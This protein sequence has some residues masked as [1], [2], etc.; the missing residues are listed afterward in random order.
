MDFWLIGILLIV[1]LALAVVI[2]K[3]KTQDA[4]LTRVERALSENEIEL[5]RRS[6]LLTAM[7]N[8]TSDGF[9]LLNKDGRIVSLNHAA[10]SLLGADNGV[11]RPLRE[12]AWG[13]ELAPLVEEV[14]LRK[15]D[16]V[17]QIIAQGE[18]AFSVRVHSIGAR[19]DAGV[20]IR[21]DEVTELQRL[22]RA[23]REFVANIS[24]ELRTPVTSLQLLVE[25][26]NAE[27]LNDQAF[28][29]GLLDKMHAQIDLLRQLTDELMELAL[30]ESGQAPIK[31][32]ETRALD[33]VN[34]AVDSLRPQAERKAIQVL[35]NVDADLDVLADAQG[36]RKVLGNLIHNAI[37]FTNTGGHIEIRAARDGENVQFAIAD[38]GIG[39]PARDLPRVF[40]RFYKVDRARTRG[41]GELRSTGLGLAIAKHTVEAHGGKIWAESIEGKGSTFF[42]TL[43]AV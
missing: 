5:T 37:K 38:T 22:G 7:N 1:L 9:I 2:W 8:A 28:L 14:V 12:M 42:F 43:P 10:H 30:I 39:I 26:I 29:V 6:D 23:R 16:S 40:E 34:E 41:V 19:A 31:F 24:H 11:G 21:L 33:L 17:E 32:V 15:A 25:T 27:T 35:I 18:R 13:Y 20:L 3:Y 36:I 4:R